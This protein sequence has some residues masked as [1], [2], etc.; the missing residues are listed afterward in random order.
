MKKILSRFVSFFPVGCFKNCCVQ[1]GHF[2]FHGEKKD[3][4]EETKAFCENQ[5]DAIA[6][7][8]AK[9]SK[10]K[11]V[12]N[13]YH[14]LKTYQKAVG[15]KYKNDCDI[16]C[17]EKNQIH[18]VSACNPGLFHDAQ[19]VKA[20][21][22]SKIEKII[23]YS[24]CNL[25]KWLVEAIGFYDKI[26]FLSSAEKQP[27]TEAFER[28]LKDENK[29]KLSDIIYFNTGSCFQKKSDLGSALRKIFENKALC[30][31]FIEFIIHEWGYDFLLK[32]EKDKCVC[33]LFNMCINELEKLWIEFVRSSR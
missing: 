7:R 17:I 31:S 9:Q 25:S 33:S 32:M 15:L 16:A 30:N 8:L 29:F 1:T 4:T 3:I 6:R 23:L 24:A 2:I 20:S 28:I 18:T 11:I 5:Y 12:I 19:S 10:D 14:D 21:L 27:Y 22:A 26:I 13:I